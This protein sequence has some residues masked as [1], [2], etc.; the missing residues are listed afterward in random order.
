MDIDWHHDELEINDQ[1]KEAISSFK[2]KSENTKMKQIK[3]MYPSNIVI[4]TDSQ[5]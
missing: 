3:H 2:F 4:T 1:L 5:I